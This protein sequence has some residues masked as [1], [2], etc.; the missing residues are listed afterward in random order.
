M[1]MIRPLEDRVVVQLNKVEE[2]TTSGI[3]LVDSA[4]ELPAEGTVVAVGP[5]RYE[6][7]IRIAQDITVGDK[8]SFHQHSGVPIKVDGEEYKIFFAREIYGVIG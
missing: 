5:G 1:V 3:I 7:G 2:K 4:K 8:V 6:N